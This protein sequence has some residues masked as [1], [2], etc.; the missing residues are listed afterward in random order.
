MAK[1][2][3]FSSLSTKC[4]MLFFLGGG[5]R[6]FSPVFPPNER[7]K[8]Q[9][10]EAKTKASENDSRKLQNELGFWNAMCRPMGTLDHMVVSHALYQLHLV[11]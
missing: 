5:A 1:R 9:S 10:S 3:W 8:N 11:C 7:A 6:N 4:E 2:E